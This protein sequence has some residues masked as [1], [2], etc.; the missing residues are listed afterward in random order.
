MLLHPVNCINISANT[1]EE[2]AP[3]VNP[4]SCWLTVIVKIEVIM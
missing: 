3:I 2:G 4:S 1:A